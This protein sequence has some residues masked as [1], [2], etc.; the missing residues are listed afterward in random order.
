MTWRDELLMQ[1]SAD[2]PCGYDRRG[3]AATEPVCLAAIAFAAYGRARESSQALQW[4]SSLQAGDGSVGVT[5]ELA[6]PAWPTALAIV[7]SGYI[8]AN[9]SADV[10][11]L[12]MNAGLP[13]AAGHDGKPFDRPR[14]ID[15]LLETKGTTQDLQPHKAGHDSLL[16]GWPWVAGTHSWIE[17]TAWAV[18]ALKSAGHGDHA[19]TR[20]AV[21]LLH[22]RLL[23]DGGCNY[24]NTTVLGQ[25]L[26]PHIQPTGLALLA[27]AGETDHDGRIERSLAYLEGEIN[28]DTTTASLAYGV[29]GLARHGRLAASANDWLAARANRTLKTDA[30]PY[31][32]A[33]LLL[34]AKAADGAGGETP[35]AKGKYV[36][37]ST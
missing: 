17:P 19:R 37:T 5:A 8:E 9:D 27:L 6:T 1:L 22:D 14:A 4:V 30:S 32:L 18:L 15:W 29:L 24:G 10:L 7:A 25:V 21:R 16:V 20:E 28:R 12:H 2:I 35:A 11:G 36:L 33:L 23:V 13:A 34:A 3:P 26:R 31:R